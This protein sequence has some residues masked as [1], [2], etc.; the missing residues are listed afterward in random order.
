ALDHVPG[1]AAAARELALRPAEGDVV[2]RDDRRRRVAGRHDLGLHG[3]CAGAGGQP[4]AGGLT[5]DGERHGREGDRD[6]RLHGRTPV[7][8]RASLNVTPLQASGA[9][10]AIVTFRFTTRALR[11]GTFSRPRNRPNATFPLRQPLLASFARTITEV[12]RIR[13]G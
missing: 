12:T 9:L 13:N 1:D 2:T 5:C 6:R 3:S 11:A 4:G 8:R 7:A 10:R